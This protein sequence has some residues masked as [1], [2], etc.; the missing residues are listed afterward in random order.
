MQ[1]TLFICPGCGKQFVRTASDYY[2]DG[3]SHCRKCFFRRV[4]PN[5]I[6]RFMYYA[7]GQYAKPREIRIERKDGK[8]GVTTDETGKRS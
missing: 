2:F 1:G 7:F 4:F 6:Q 3:K 8:W 5:P